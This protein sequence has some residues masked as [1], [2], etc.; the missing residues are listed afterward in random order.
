MSKKEI[1]LIALTVILAGIY[2][3]YFTDWFRPKRIR[4]EHTIRPYLD[5]RGSGATAPA[6]GQPG[7]FI[8]T[9]ALSH[10][11]RLT[12]V[13]VVALSEWLTNKNARPLWHLVADTRPQPTKAIVYGVNLPGMKPFVAGSPP[14]PL[15]PNIEYRLLIEAGW[16][17]RGEH[18][19]KIAERSPGFR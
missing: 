19:F 6:A 7:R 15:E 11:C 14:A 4:I 9:F 17:T 13:K 5:P 2:V 16:P 12:S 1:F 18:D 10:E 8:V 3:R